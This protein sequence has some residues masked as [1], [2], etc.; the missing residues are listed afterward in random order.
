MLAAAAAGECGTAFISVRMSDIRD[1]FVGESEKNIRAVFEAAKEYES[2]IIFFD[3]IDALGGKKS[4][5]Q[6][7]H[8]R[9]LINELLSQMD[10]LEKKSESRQIL[11]LAAT[12]RPWDLDLALRRPGRFDTAIF[13]P[14]P[15]FE[16]RKQL[17]EITLRN[18]PVSSV[19]TILLA[20]MTDGYSSAEI[21]N[22]CQNAAKIPLRELIHESKE[23]RSIT[24]DD[25]IKAILSTQP[26]LNTWYSNARSEIE[27]SAEIDAFQDLMK[28]AEKSSPQKITIYPTMITNRSLI[29]PK[30]LF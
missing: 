14:H 21:V 6:E 23:R 30:R 2:S 3:E 22:I 4:D 16:S 9:T 11:I 25:F 19:D 1:K 5:N 12:N 24:N 20:E 17:F 28:E 15:D 27:K 29:H 7:L 18:R 26:S 8:E 10:G 13:I